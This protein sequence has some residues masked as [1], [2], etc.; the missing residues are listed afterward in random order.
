MKD[1]R[2][3]IEHMNRYFSDVIAYDIDYF[4]A[5]DELL[6]WVKPYINNK[7]IDTLARVYESIGMLNRSMYELQGRVNYSCSFVNA[8][9]VN[10]SCCCYIANGQKDYAKTLALLNYTYQCNEFERLKESNESDEITLPFN[11]E[12]LGDICLFFDCEK[13]QDYYEQAKELFR[14]MSPADQGG[15]TNDY[16]FSKYVDVQMVFEAC[17]GMFLKVK[18]DGVERIEQKEAIMDKFERGEL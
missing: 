13:A 16:Y 17:F 5:S 12:L 11:L 18:N 6:E 7:K 14:H 1:Y 15:E 3:L 8:M 2:K 10:I 9:M 4:D